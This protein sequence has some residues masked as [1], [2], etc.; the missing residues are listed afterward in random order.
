MYFLSLLAIVI[1]GVLSGFEGHDACETR[2]PIVRPPP[3]PVNRNGEPVHREAQGTC[4]DGLP[5]ASSFFGL[6][7][8]WS[9]AGMCPAFDAAFTVAA[10][11]DGI[12]DR[13]PFSLPC[14]RHSPLCVRVVPVSVRPI[15][16]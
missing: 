4:V 7:T 3:T 6:M 9:G 16:I 2:G 14:S 13:V 15:V 12:R 10:G 5:L 11:P 8:V 1:S